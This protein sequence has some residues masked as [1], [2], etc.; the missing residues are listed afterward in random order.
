M[1]NLAVFNAKQHKIPLNKRNKFKSIRISF[2]W[3]STWDAC[4]HYVYV[5]NA[6]LA[7]YSDRFRKLL[8]WSWLNVSRSLRLLDDS[9][10]SFFSPLV[11]QVIMLAFYEHICN[12]C[13]EICNLPCFSILYYST[14]N[15]IWKK[16]ENNQWEFFYEL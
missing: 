13:I 12:A 2:R 10:C 1:A 11:L 16:N 3:F 5:N 8:I 6:F 14:R 9:S 4:M 15:K 7:H